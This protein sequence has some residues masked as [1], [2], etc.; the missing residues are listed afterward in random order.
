MYIHIFFLFSVRTVNIEALILIVY[1][2]VIHTVVTSQQFE[3]VDPQSNSE[4]LHV[5][6][7]FVY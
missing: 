6:L 5:N 4:Y 2:F 1:S 3:S 7:T